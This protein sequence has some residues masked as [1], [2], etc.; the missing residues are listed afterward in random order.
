MT[1]NQNSNIKIDVAFLVEGEKW[2]VK[3]SREETI[4]ALKTA[5]YQLISISPKQ[6]VLVFL[7]KRLKN[8]K[9]LKHYKIGSD[10]LLSLIIEST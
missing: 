2:V 7:G 5:I 8:H 4:L 3:I 9:T 6:Q 1:I 10:S